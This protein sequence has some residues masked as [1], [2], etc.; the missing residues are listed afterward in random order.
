MTKLAT[1]P[2]APSVGLAKWTGI[3]VK[4]GPLVSLRILHLEDDPHDAELVRAALE[5]EGLSCEITRVETQSAFRSLLEQDGLGLI[6]VD[7]TLP[8]FDGISA[9]KLAKEVSPDIPFIF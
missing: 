9:L 8:S 3:S 2:S 7:F 5:D 6:L 4:P 1:N